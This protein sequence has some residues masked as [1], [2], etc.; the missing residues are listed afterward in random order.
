M[1]KARILADY[2]AGGTTAAEFDYM[3]GVTSN[4]QT[5]LDVRKPVRNENLV[6][7]YNSE[8]DVFVDADYLTLFDSSNLAYIA[9]SV[10]LTATITTSGVNG[11]DTG[12]EASSTWYHIWVIYNGTT[13]ASLLSASSTAPTMPSG[14]TYKKYVGAVYN[15]S[16][17]NFD[18][19]M[20]NGNSVDVP[21]VQVASGITTTT[22]IDL[23]A[24]VPPTARRIWA[25]GRQ[26]GSS[27]TG[28]V[29]GE[30]TSRTTAT[31]SRGKHHAVNCQFYISGL[32]WGQGGSV[33][34][35][36]HT[37]STFQ[38]YGGSSSLCHISKY[39]FDNIV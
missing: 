21:V 26:A 4:V 5:Q 24:F 9:S 19:F 13:V 28:N 31:D 30:I 14:Y 38:M 22:T 8:I 20:Q 1:T 15:G 6:V 7:K 12:S 10:D 39:E 18:D 25:K 2:V 3:D 11:L 34:C 32:D 29:G 37:D 36:L 27:T 16:D 33:Y 23:S 35:R 17:N